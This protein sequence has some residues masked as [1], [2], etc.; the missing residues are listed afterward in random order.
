MPAYRVYKLDSHGKILGPPHII[1]CDDDA[2]AVTEATA[3][4][5][6]F[7]LE[8]WDHGRRVAVIPSKHHG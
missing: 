1:E 5:D 4:V 2:A 6:G 8:L 3:Y 7:D